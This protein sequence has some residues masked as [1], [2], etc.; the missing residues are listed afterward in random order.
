MRDEVFL[1]KYRA[2]YEVLAQLGGRLGAH[3]QMVLDQLNKMGVA[4]TDPAVVFG[5]YEDAMEAAEEEFVACHYLRKL[6]VKRHGG[7]IT[8]L[9][10]QF[11]LGTDLGGA[12]GN[13]NFL[14]EF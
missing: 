4:P 8:H 10:N 6:N 2:Y 7:L 12:V 5:A 11:T 3:P 13:C 9:Q 1:G 14:N